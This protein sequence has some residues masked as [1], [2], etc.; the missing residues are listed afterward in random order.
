MILFAISCVST[1]YVDAH[2]QHVRLLRCRSDA[3]VRLLRDDA[4]Y[5]A[6][7]LVAQKALA[8]HE[9]MYAGWLPCRAKMSAMDTFVLDVYQDAVPDYYDVN[10][11]P[12]SP[13]NPTPAFLAEHNRLPR[14][15]LADLQADWLEVDALLTARGTRKCLCLLQPARNPDPDTRCFHTLCALSMVATL[16]PRGWDVVLVPPDA[17]MHTDGSWVHYD[18]AWLQDFVQSALRLSTVAP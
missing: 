9:G 5:V 4:A 18:P 3:V 17:P 10:G 12:F 1:P 2:P 8:H 14:R 16:A 13:Y 6:D 11:L 7:T 15:C